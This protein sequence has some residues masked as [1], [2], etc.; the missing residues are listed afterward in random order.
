MSTTVI[1]ERL[2]NAP[3]QQVWKAITDKEQMKR[4]YFDLSDFKPEIG[5]EFSFPGQGHKGEQYLHLC[6]VKEVVVEKKLAYS[7]TYKDQP[8]YSVV[9]FEL[10][11]EQGGTRVKLTH[12]GIETFPAHPDFAKESFTEGWT[13]IIGTALNEF[14]QSS[15]I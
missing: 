4:W 15:L 11:P 1:I 5:F 2:F 10:I 12:Q 13:Y 9:T 6:T 14:L 3:V 8:G 7:W